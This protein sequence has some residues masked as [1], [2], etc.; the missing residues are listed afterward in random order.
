MRALRK[1]APTVAIVLFCSATV[2]CGGAPGDPLWQKALGIARTNADWVAGLVIT[3]S[4]VIYKGETNG[5]REIWERAEPG[6]DGEVVRRTIKILEDGKDVTGR[7]K[8]KQKDKKTGGQGI[9]NPFNAEIQD[10]LVL[11]ATNRLRNIAGQDCV[12][13]VFEVRNTNG[14]KTRGI[15]WLEKETGVPAELENV[16]VEPLPDKHLKGMTI[17]T[18]Y[19]STTEGGWRVKEMLTIGKVGMLFINADF[20]ST[21]QFSE[22]WKRRPKR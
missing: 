8:Q 6:A 13:Y 20:Q 11:A 1:A 21:M 14:P 16:T 7:E 22:Y 2:V 18:R 17:T 9:G 19:E 15:A 3:H 12:G 4:E 10:R 5:V